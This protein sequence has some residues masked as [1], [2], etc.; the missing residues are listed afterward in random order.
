MAL[1]RFFADLDASLPNGRPVEEVMQES[2]QVLRRHDV[3]V[4]SFEPAAV[5][6]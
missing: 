3:T 2:R 6:G 5:T 1:G 4:V